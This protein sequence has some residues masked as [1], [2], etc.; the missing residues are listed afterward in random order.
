[1]RKFILAGIFLMLTSTVHAAVMYDF[2]GTNKKNKMAFANQTID[3]MLTQ[4]E[5]KNRERFQELI[6]CDGDD[7]AI[8]DVLSG[9]YPEYD[10]HVHYCLK[11]MRYRKSETTHEK[12]L[13]YCERNSQFM[14]KNNFRKRQIEFGDFKCDIVSENPRDIVNVAEGKAKEANNDFALVS[15]AREICVGKW[16]FFVEYASVVSKM[17]PEK[18]QE[19]IDKLKGLSAVNN[20]VANNRKKGL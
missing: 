8:I 13:D 15:I 18:K 11:F 3:E 5:M 10:Q 19:I 12:L 4:E 1:M 7:I 6:Q 2:F 20:W 17:T 14:L 16:S 9:N